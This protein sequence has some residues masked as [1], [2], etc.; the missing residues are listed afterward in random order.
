MPYTEA[1]KRANEKWKR[2]NTKMVGV[3]MR[4]SLA[5]D[6]EAVCTKNG[7]TRNA[8]LL[9]YVRR[10]VA[11]GGVPDRSADADTATTAED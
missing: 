10:Y 7:T 5:A 9:D 8:V 6:F 1:Q 4:D 2:A 3:R 11:A